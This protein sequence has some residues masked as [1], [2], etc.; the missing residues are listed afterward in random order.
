MT[1][2]CK[3]LLVGQANIYYCCSLLLPLLLSDSKYTLR[4]TTK[5]LLCCYVNRQTGRQTDRER[6]REREEQR[7]NEDG[8]LRKACADC[9]TVKWKCVAFLPM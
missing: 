7:E 5:L 8:L 4:G 2:A 3:R 9:V 6:E 1:V